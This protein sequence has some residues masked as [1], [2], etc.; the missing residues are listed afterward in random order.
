MAVR[1]VLM[2]QDNF[3]YYDN[4][5]LYGNNKVD[6][7]P[8]RGSINL[9]PVTN[10]TGIFAHLVQSHKVAKKKS[11][12]IEISRM[13]DSERSSEAIHH[14]LSKVKVYRSKQTSS[15]GN[16]Y[17]IEKCLQEREMK[18]PNYDSEFVHSI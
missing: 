9:N 17:Y 3:P 10:Y 7:A 11:D 6:P 14:D 8:P 5:V 18:N 12:Q 1:Q 16:R 15:R 4:G 2:I 13:R